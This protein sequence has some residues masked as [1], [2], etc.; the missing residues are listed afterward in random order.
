MRPTALLSLTVLFFLVLAL[1]AA[2]QSEV[3]EVSFA[4]SGSPA[5]QAPFL[6]GL[7]LLHD[8]EY[9]DA[10]EQFRAAQKVDPDFA[11]AY[12]GEALTHTHPVWMQQ[13]LDAARAVLARLGATPEARLA[14][15]KTERERDYLR[16][17]E[18][19]YG[20]G[21]KEERD[22]RYS[23]AL[24]ALHQRYPDDVDATAFY[25]LSLLGTAH[26][27][28]DFATYMRS[29][30]LLEEVFPTHP[31]HPGVLHYLIHSYDDPIHA[32][33]GMRAA[34][35][36]GKVA[37]NAGHA[38]H[39]TS[40]IFVALG[41]WDDVIAANEQ[42]MRVVNQQR[43]AHGQPPKT[44]GH[45]VTWLHYAYLQERRFDEAKQQLDA[46][47][48]M[49]TAELASA[50]ASSGEPAPVYDFAQMRV[51]HALATGKWDAA[52]PLV[53][54][55]ASYVEPKFTLA[56]G[57]ALVAASGDLAALHAAAARLR[58]RQ[59]DFLAAIVKR[60]EINPADRQRAEILVQQIDA[61]ERIREGRKDEGIARLRQA[62]AAE[63]AMAL[64]FG[65]PAIA[66][67]T[68]ELLGDELLALG[69]NAEAEQAYQSALSRAPGRTQSLQ[70]LLR[71]QQALGQTD[72]A[73]RTREQ[74]GRYVRTAAK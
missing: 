2:A 56:Y 26:Q 38:L 73:E 32:P 43:A 47:R 30:A 70:G 25:A 18:V 10:A 54:P 63:T 4:N 68:W 49:V 40:H 19:L 57:E 66:K 3:G 35:L 15:A 7:A 28:R 13:D 67:P 17:L 59:K 58:E 1:P 8:F 11:M 53:L 9:P 21:T 39:M 31:H 60:Q 5:A 27:G 71:T 29:A 34:R 24:A 46:C 74:V 16:T 50:K 33:L 36:Y 48:H 42:A 62:A 12:W 6:R 45:Y 51:N 65:P 69:R 55:A 41:L 72:A 52:D 37:P 61:L 23:D 22:C 20:S 14:R 64:E 44:C